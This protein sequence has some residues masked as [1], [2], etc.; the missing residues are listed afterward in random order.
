M[1]ALTT[2]PALSGASPRGPVRK[3]ASLRRVLLIYTGGTIGMLH[4]KEKGLIPIK[5]NLN[6]LVT[7]MNIQKKMKIKYYI[8]QIK[9]QCN[10]D[11]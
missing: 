3:S 4:N 11:E 2:S 9:L 7:N 5:G 6:R 1:S 10:K 8:D